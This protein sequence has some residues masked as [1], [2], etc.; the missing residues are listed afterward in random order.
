MYAHAV[1][2]RCGANQ[3]V[4]EQPVFPKQGG[5][6]MEKERSD[7]EYVEEALQQGEEGFRS[8]IQS[9]SD[10]ILIIDRS[11]RITYESPS[12]SKILGYEPGYSIGKSP[13]GYV[14]PDDMNEAIKHLEDVFRS[15]NDGLPTTFKCLKADNT[16]IY[17]EVVGGN[18]IDNPAI[19]G[20]VITVRDV[21]ERKR[22]EAAFRKSEAEKRVILDSVSDMIF[23]IDTNMRV[24]Y[25][26]LAVKT[27]FN[28]TAGEL[29][30][31]ACYLALHHRDRPCRVCPAIMAM[32]S[33]TP[34]EAYASS[35]GR[36]WR[37]RGYPVK[38]EDGT[39]SGAIEVVSDTTDLRNAEEKYRSI[40]E[41]AMEGIYQS[42]LDG[43][44]IGANPALAR[45]FGYDSAET[46]MREVTN[47]GKQMYADPEKR[48]AF[49]RQ[50]E[51]QGLVKDFEF[52]SL[53]KD[54]ERIYISDSARA[55]MDGKGT[56]L[57]FEGNIQDITVRRRAEEALREN[58]ERFRALSENAP[59]IIY[60][61]NLQGVITYAN[62]AWKRFLG[63]DSDDLMGRYF[64]DFAREEDRKTYRKLFRSIRDE[65]NIVSNYIGIMLTK[66]GRERLF[67]MN[68]SFNRDAK[69]RIIGV[70]GAMKDITE[71]RVMEK[72]LAQ[73][74]KMEAIGT[75]AGGIAH[76]FN[77]L[78]MGI[79]GYASLMR[80]DLD[81]SH[82]H[83]ERLKQIEQQVQSGADLTRQLLGFARGGK[84][85]SKAADMNEI[86]DRTLSIF[87]RTKKE[88]AVQKSLD[89]ALWAVDVDQGQMEQ[90]LMN[91]YVN[92]WQ[93]MPGGGDLSLETS[94]VLLDDN[95]AMSRAINP[96]R[97]VK[98]TIADTG[99]GMDAKT[100]E[101]I[102][103][104]FFTTKGMGRGTGLGLAT[105]YGI[106]K[107]HGGGIDVT[108]EPGRGTTFEIYLPATEK[109]IVKEQNKTTTILRGKETVLLVD[110]EP[111]VLEVTRELMEALGYRVFLAGSG[112]EAIAVF[113][114]K[115]K[116]IDMV[117][118]DMV[119]PGISGNETFDRLR[120]IDPQLVILLSSGYSINGQAQQIL[121]K[122][123]N[124]FIQKPFKLK[125]L[126][127]K[128]RE[129]LGGNRA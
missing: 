118:L 86:I 98:I 113:L 101:R 6:D 71:Q 60:T 59:D 81:A 48:L 14:H 97:Y 121:K 47:I 57:Y 66:N 100:R 58:E 7:R 26:N 116:M 2:D 56:L 128:L 34:Y 21:N 35:F 17:V 25:S 18:H 8:L 15:A 80:L 120:E 65:K 38:D 10:M 107:G 23:Y 92:A 115:R 72:K 5:A 110:D 108:S 123:C 44:L 64:I 96:G 16:W 29:E 37:L 70:V 77:N 91:L 52:E 90:T 117:I 24:I 105:V 46:M 126:S 85:E 75:L 78:L 63:H 41:N 27:F 33:G 83:Y 32:E 82:P 30:G 89:D 102:F 93:A 11:G 119:M 51:E 13:L 40:F 55:V 112:Q 61:M 99:L 88:I 74:Q 50:V 68:S 19:Q 79:Q 49:L 109:A 124:G 9:L 69:G 36:H 129:V 104:P 39:I 45:I 125:A 84:Y 95:Q 94:N 53:K 20:I 122:G 67:S 4:I 127:Q 111:I 103:D 42:N 28:C 3:P 1:K 31:K 87:A 76:D 43:C 12:V 114:E 54:G 73:A 106:V 22:A 62:P